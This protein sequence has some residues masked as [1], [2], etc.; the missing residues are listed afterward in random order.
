MRYSDF[1]ESVYDPWYAFVSKE[2]NLKFD[3]QLQMFIYACIACRDQHCGSP[4]LKDRT[5][6]IHNYAFEGKIMISSDR[7]TLI[8]C[9]LKSAQNVPPFPN[10]LRK[11]QLIDILINVKFYIKLIGAYLL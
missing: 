10:L 11:F 1:T 3:Y 6:A 2:K 4:F 5:R 7:R 9:L 8:T